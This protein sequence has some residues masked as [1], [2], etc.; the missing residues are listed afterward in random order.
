MTTET[1]PTTLTEETAQESM[2]F[3]QIGHSY[4]DHSGTMQRTRNMLNEEVMKY[5]THISLEVAKVQIY[6]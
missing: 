4:E 1:F 3:S 2:G 6:Q 5:S